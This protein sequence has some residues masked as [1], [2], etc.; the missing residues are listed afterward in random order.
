MQL[1]YLFPSLLLRGSPTLAS[2]C[3]CFPG[4]SCWPSQGHW[5]SLNNT[6]EGRLIATVPLGS[7]CHDPT[8]DEDQ[9]ASLQNQWLDSGIHMNSSSSVMAPFFANR[10]CDPFQPRSSPCTLGNYVRYSIH[11]TGPDDVIAAI[12]FAK[13]N[14]VRFVIRNTGH[15]Y[16]GRSTGAG[17]LAIWTHHLKSIEP[18]DWQGCSYN[19]KALKIGAGVQGF[20][21]LIAAFGLG[22]V[23]VTGECPTVGLAGGY[24]QGGGHSALSTKFGLAADNTLSFE[25]VTASG[26]LVTA[27]RTQNSDLYWALS[28]GGAGNYGVVVSMTVKAHPD[29]VVSGV[30]FSVA[31]GDSQT[32]EQ[33]FDAIDALHASITDIVDSGI[34]VIYYFATG[35]LQIPALTAY[36]KTRSE[37]EQILSP[38]LAKL[39]SMGL[40]YTITYTEFSSYLDHYEHYWGPL[41]LG[42]IQVGTSQYGG[43]LIKR[44]QILNFRDTARAIA[45]QGVMF[46]GVG[47]NVSRFGGYNAVLPAWREAIVHGILSLPWNFTAPWAE[48][49]DTQRKMT[50]IIQPIIEVATPGSGAYMN[51]ADWRQPDFQ[52]VFFGSNYDKLL[53]IK[54]K[55][56]PTGLFYAID[57]V[58]SEAYTVQE[59]ARLC[60]TL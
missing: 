19:G 6:V 11:A 8:Y 37:L 46:S 38:F 55:W 45:D 32:T 57:A 52:E 4:D 27:S 36:E 59:A 14:D 18:L 58:G 23:V 44:P 16:L 29:R 39:D 49:L 60:T 1:S 56:D 12:R 2:T 53:A 40:V 42:N 41:P 17:S 25:V 10:S 26:D 15:D 48:G 20:E 50:D 3:K 28:G 33:V 35:Y 7:P 34:M 31:A 30:K 54:K 13:E 24:T 9:C 5:D 51:E 47:T 21:A 22:L 43:R